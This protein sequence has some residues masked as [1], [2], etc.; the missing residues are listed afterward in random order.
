M[1]FF[2]MLALMVVFYS[3]KGQSSD[4][5]DSRVKDSRQDKT[6]E[7]IIYSFTIMQSVN[8][9]W[10]YDIFKDGRR[11]IHQTSIPGLP[12]N[13]GFK[14]KSDAEKV[15]QLVIAKLKKGEMPPS[16]TVDEL[17]K[18]KIL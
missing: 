5:Y 15:A 6:Q 17:E 7:E 2:L 8:N 10:Y 1:K 18:M 11:F 12:G 13:E 3:S 4:V 9:T 16:V 14:N